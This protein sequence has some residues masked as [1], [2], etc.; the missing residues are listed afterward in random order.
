MIME[1]KDPALT[2]A[3]ISSHDAQAEII[4]DT[5]ATHHNEHSHHALIDDI[6]DDEVKGTQ[7]LQETIIGSNLIDDIENLDNDSIDAS[8][9]NRRTSRQIA[10]ESVTHEEPLRKVVVSEELAKRDVIER[11]TG[12]NT[13]VSAN[14]ASTYDSE[15]G[16]D[17]DKLE[18]D[19]SVTNHTDTFK[20]NRVGSEHVNDGDNPARQP[21]RR[22]QQGSTAF[23]EGINEET[24]GSEAPKSEDINDR[25]RYASIDNAQSRVLA[26]DQEGD[27]SITPK[28]MG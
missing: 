9:A 16:Y 8:D 13:T 25:N 28:G 23:D 6:A 15:V 24:V 21:D 20:D 1:T 17:H 2:K 3:P 4:K 12:S 10:G 26:P 18:A 22:D 14:T 7:V 11:N 27:E 5:T 19:T